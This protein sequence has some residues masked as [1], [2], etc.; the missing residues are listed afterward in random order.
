MP[1]AGKV[2][3][4]WPETTTHRF[5]VLMELTVHHGPPLGSEKAGWALYIEEELAITRLGRV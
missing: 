4:M 3:G 2:M 5:H 1:S